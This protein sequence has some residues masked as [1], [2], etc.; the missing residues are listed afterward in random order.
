MSKCVAQ[1]Q[2]K[3]HPE[4]ENQRGTRLGSDLGHTR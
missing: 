2:A 1:G 3:T 4:E